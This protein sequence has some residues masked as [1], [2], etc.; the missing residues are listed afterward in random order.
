MPANDHLIH[1]GELEPP[2]QRSLHLNLHGQA[3]NAVLRI[4]DISKKLLANIPSLH[5]DL[6]EVAMYVYA[7][8]SA[9]S[10]GTY[11]D[12]RMGRRWRRNFQFI[13]PV[14]NVGLWS[15]DGVA[16]IL[17]ETLGFLSDD[18]YSFE[19]KP[20]QTPI[21]GEAYFEF[22][23][24][25]NAAF[26]PDEVILFSGGLDSFAGAVDTLA[27]AGKSVALV[28]HRSSPKMEHKQ[29]N[30]VCDLKERVGANRIFHVPVR[31]SLRGIRS[32][33]DAHRS[34]SFLFAAL[35]AVTARLFGVNCINF[36]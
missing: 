9:T 22:G 2:K 31:A 32:L 24:N 15:S 26:R 5:L 17:T 11:D 20:I 34:R 35:G 3:A 29:Y 7:A 12:V 10:R 18:E 36:F 19:F 23:A 13:I 33:N 21:G 4:E 27:V 25:N 28:N 1:C 8:D 14:R 30:L 6:L 16:T